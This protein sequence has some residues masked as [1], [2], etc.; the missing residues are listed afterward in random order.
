MPDK[1]KK[2]AVVVAVATGLAAA[3]AVLLKVPAD[4]VLPIWYAVADAIYSLF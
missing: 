1:V 4:T 3:T 2:P